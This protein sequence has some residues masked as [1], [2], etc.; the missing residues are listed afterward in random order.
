MSRDDLLTYL[1]AA[2]TAARR[3]AQPGQ[4]HWTRGYIDALDDIAEYVQGMDP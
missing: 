4:D 2:R 3:S 1:D